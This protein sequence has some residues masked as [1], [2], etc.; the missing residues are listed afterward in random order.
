MDL[1]P[2]HSFFNELNNRISRYNHEINDLKMTN[3]NLHR[4]V[5]D[6]R[7]QI[8]QLNFQINSLNQRTNSSVQVQPQPQPQ[9]ISAPVVV[10]Q[11]VESKIK[12]VSGVRNGD[13]CKFIINSE[14]DYSSV[15]TQFS[16]DGVNFGNFSAPFAIAKGEGISIERFAPQTKKFFRLFNLNGS[17]IISNT[18]EF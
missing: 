13:S 15:F 16:D 9:V 10:E 17:T 12:I 4:Q 18:L 14:Q 2:L 5:D 3:G 8:N 11:K 6:M 7:N 1:S